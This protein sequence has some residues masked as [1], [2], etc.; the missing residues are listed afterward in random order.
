MQNAETVL[1]VLECPHWASL[2]IELVA[3]QAT[4]PA[5]MSGGP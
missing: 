2:R 3:R 1:G 4:P 5:F